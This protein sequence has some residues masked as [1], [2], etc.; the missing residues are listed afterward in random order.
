MIIFEDMEV[1]FMFRHIENIATVS[2]HKPPLLPTPALVIT[3]S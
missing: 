1:D 3:V 2:F